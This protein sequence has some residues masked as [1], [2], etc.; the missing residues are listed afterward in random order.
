MRRI[1]NIFGALRGNRFLAL[2]VVLLAVVLFWR[3]TPFGE[4]I[5]I[6]GIVQ[7]IK[8]MA[9]EAGGVPPAG[10]PAAGTSKPSAVSIAAE[11][12]KDLAGRA[13]AA[14]GEVLTTPTNQWT[15]LLRNMNIWQSVLLALLVGF[16]LRRG[17][18]PWLANLTFGQA[19]ATGQA[20][21]QQARRAPVLQ[22]LIYGGIGLGLVHIVREAL[23]AGWETLP[24]VALT[25]ML[26]LM[27]LAWVVRTIPSI[28]ET[29][30]RFAQALAGILGP[31]VEL[32]RRGALAY[33]GASWALAIPW[34]DRVSSI[35]AVATLQPRPISLIVNAATFGM[36]L[37]NTLMV[38]AWMTLV[39]ILFF[40]FL[41]AGDIAPRRAGAGGP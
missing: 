37:A 18:L 40:A 8:E 24:E 12:G 41:A 16:L 7:T 23:A 10:P 27:V 11:K 3:F 6:G 4:K 2:A 20:I 17:A 14:S 15:R 32:I 30:S 19:I 34:G 38:D 26:P 9:P 31:G 21:D 1:K 36:Q 25:R 35:S 28:Q 5:P 29:L 39:G 13:A 22:W 33:F